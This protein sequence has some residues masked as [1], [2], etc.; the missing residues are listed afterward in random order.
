MGEIIDKFCFKFTD[1]NL[2]ES[3][4]ILSDK[5]DL[6]VTWKVNVIENLIDNYC[7]S[8]F[9][10]IQL[11]QLDCDPLDADCT[12]TTETV[13]RFPIKNFTYT[14]KRKLEACAKYKYNIIEKR[15]EETKPTDEVLFNAREQFQKIEM[16]I[17]QER[18]QLESVQVD[19]VYDDYPL[20]PK[21]FKI[22]V[23]EGTTLMREF[24]TNETYETVND[25]EPCVTYS[26]TVFPIGS[27]KLLSGDTKMYTMLPALPSGIRNLSI[28][29]NPDEK[30][31]DVNW[32]E[33]REASKCVKDYVVIAQSNVDNRE[34]VREKTSEKI[35]DVFACIT[36][37]IKLY[38]TTFF[39]GLKGAE[40]SKEIRIPS[41]GWFKSSIET[42]RNQFYYFYN[43]YS[44]Y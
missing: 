12:G 6:T 4:Y 32:V 13:S 11:V 35:V 41:R 30:Y 10:D 37:T 3:S 39:D 22:E 19:W 15:W 34:T 8:V 40:V 44:I 31:L 28:I 17:T 16:S 5:N 38:A 14:F 18:D 7:D 2:T 25:L 9:I 33:P 36:Y 24:D 26:I 1:C 20:C 23:R 43:F 29:Y 21:K 27:D 42:C